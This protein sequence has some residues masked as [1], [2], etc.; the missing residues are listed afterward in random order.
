MT[1]VIVN[2]FST[3]LKLDSIFFYIRFCILYQQVLSQYMIKT[4]WIVIKLKL[5]VLKRV[6]CS[7][8]FWWL[9]IHKKSGKKTS[10]SLASLT[11]SITS[12]DEKNPIC[13]NPILLL[14]RLVVMAE[15]EESVE[16]YFDFEPT[17]C[18]ESCFMN[19]LMWGNHTK[20]S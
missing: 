15:R 4:Q 10:V 11:R 1:M 17:H 18:P 8:E 14:T 2:N 19:Q 12:T 20:Y 16:Q 9:K 13:I 6:W 7:G 3:G 5:L